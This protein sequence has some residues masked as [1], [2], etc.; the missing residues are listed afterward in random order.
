MLANTNRGSIGERIMSGT[1]EVLAE[2][3]LVAGR[4]YAAVDTDRF[5]DGTKTQRFLNLKNR[6]EYWK[7]FGAEHGLSEADVAAIIES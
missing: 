2:S 3:T 6:S 7:Q 1:A 4:L 5:S